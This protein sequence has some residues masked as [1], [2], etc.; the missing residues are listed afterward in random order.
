MNPKVKG[1][2]Q[3]AALPSL[4]R[5]FRLVPQLQSGT[6]YCSGWGPR[7]SYFTKSK[8]CLKAHQ[9]PC[10]SVHWKP[11]EGC[12]TLPDV[13]W[14]SELHKKP[15]PGFMSTIS[16]LGKRRISRANPNPSTR[17]SEF[18]NNFQSTTL[19]SASSYYRI[20]I[21]NCVHH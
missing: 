13:Q 17:H 18:N 10:Q 11:L 7:L 6:I 16:K 8:F 4:N 21:E 5:E 9:Q 2:A 15:S 1:N 19:A 3:A 20:S 14:L 12:T